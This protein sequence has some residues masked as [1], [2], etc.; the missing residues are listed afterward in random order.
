MK[1]TMLL[2]AVLAERAGGSRTLEVSG[3]TLGEVLDHV[4]VEHAELVEVIRGRQ[5]ISRFMN[6]YVNQID[7][8]DSGGLQTR[9]EAGDEITVVPAVAGG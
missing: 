1:A 8:R 2:P 7:V 4:A 6:I 9:I 3:R 5:G